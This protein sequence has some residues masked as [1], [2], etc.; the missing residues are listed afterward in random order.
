MACTPQIE[1][2]KTNF[3]AQEPIKILYWRKKTRTLYTY[4]SI[5]IFFGELTV[6]SYLLDKTKKCKNPKSFDKNMKR[7]LKRQFRLNLT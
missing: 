1:T 3:K 6:S 2:P 5:Y 4:I 7:A